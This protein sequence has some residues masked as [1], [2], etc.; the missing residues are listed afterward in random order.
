M[1]TAAE[2]SFGRLSG[3]TFFLE[4]DDMTY[5]KI[6]PPEC[7]QGRP[8]EWWTSMVEAYAFDDEPHAIALLTQAAVQLQRIEQFRAAIDSDG[9]VIQDRF[10]CVKEHPAAAAERA[11][12]NLFRLL[13]RELGI[14]PAN[15]DP[16][17]PR[18]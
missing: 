2:A 12:T 5:V 4:F 11:A 17:P 7:I 3:E 15:D 14:M 9:V 16:R 10:E 6:Q 13:V 18:I 1:E 8:R